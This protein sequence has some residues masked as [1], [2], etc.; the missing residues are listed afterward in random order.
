M[1]DGFDFDG[2]LKELFERD[3]PTLLN[4]LTGGIP[5]RSFLSV[6]KPR[7]QQ[8]RLDL[9]LLLA[10]D[11]IQHVELQS[12]NSNK[13]RFRM[14]G[15]WVVLKD[16]WQRKIRQAVLFVGRGR[17]SMASTIEEDNVRYSFDLI[18]IRDINAA[19]LLKGNAGDLALAVLAGGGNKLLPEILRKAARLKGAA[20]ERALAQILVL[21]GLRGLV[22]KVESEMKNMGVV[23]DVRKNRVL[24][25]WRKEAIEEGRV[26]GKAEGRVEGRV[27]GLEEGR[28]RGLAEGR[29]GLLRHVLEAK[30]GPLPPWAQDRLGKGTTR[31]FDRWAK[32]ALACDSLE[33]VL[34][35]R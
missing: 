18:D 17:M 6:E 34:G 25:K 13:V 7:V 31:D 23:I 27:A 21:S 12:V 28:S 33:A 32:K 22:G 4:R 9:V 3:R 19:E 1:K 29:A 15:Y 30:F 10:D 8:R 11:R 14:L 5:V 16:E 2:A 20:R 24:M 26:E 35:K